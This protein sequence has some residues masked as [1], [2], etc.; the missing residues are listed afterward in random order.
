VRL[1]VCQG[2]YRR[3]I[4]RRIFYGK[5]I[6]KRKKLTSTSELGLKLFKLRTLLSAVAVRAQ[7]NP[8]II[9][10]GLAL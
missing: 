10:N 6:D 1:Y 7:V 3:L 4:D 9:Q 8:L 5:C 2:I